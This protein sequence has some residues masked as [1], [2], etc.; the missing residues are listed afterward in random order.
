MDELTSVE[1]YEFK[2]PYIEYQIKKLSPG[3]AWWYQSL[4]EV[5]PEVEAINLTKTEQETSIGEANLENL[6]ELDLR[7]L[8]SR[9]SDLF[10]R[11][12]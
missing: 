4:G 3:W 6:R 10:Q 1:E 5:M 9:E 8:P 7:V 2:G 11:F 12:L